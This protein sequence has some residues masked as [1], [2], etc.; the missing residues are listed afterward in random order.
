[1]SSLTVK[2]NFLDAYI[3]SGIF[4]AAR[5][6]VCFVMAIACV[7]SVFARVLSPSL[8]AA[9]TTAPDYV[10]VHGGM[11]APGDVPQE[12][13]LPV[14]IKL[15]DESAE[16]PDEVTVL[17]RRGQFVLAY[18]PVGLLNEVAQSG[19]ISRMEGGL[20]RIPH[21][22]H[23]REFTSFPQVEE[24]VGLPATYTGKNVVTGFSDT[25]FDPHHPAFRN[26]EDGTLRVKALTNYGSTPSQISRLETSEEIN[27]WVTDLDDEWHATHVAG[28]MAGG[29]KGNLYYGIATE[30]DI[31]ATTGLL[32]DATMLA[33][34]ED[35]IEYARNEG[36]PAVINLSVSSEIGPHD[37]TSLFSQY[38]RMLGDEAV[39]CIA[40]G[41]NGQRPAYWRTRFPESTTVGAGFVDVKSWSSSRAS[42][43]MD[44]WSDDGSSFCFALTVVNPVTKEVIYREEFPAIKDDS[45]ETHYVITSSLDYISKEEFGALHRRVSKEFAKY[46]DGYVAVITEINPDNHRFNAYV[47]L[48]ASSLQTTDNSQGHFQ[49]GIEVSG[50]ENTGFRAYTSDAVRYEILKE[51]PKFPYIGA[52]GAINDFI[53]GDGVIGIGAMTS[54]N[55]WPLINGTEAAGS[56]TEGAPASFSS[57]STELSLPEIS[58]PG[59][60]LVSAISKPFLDKHPD[61]INSTSV[62]SQV[63]NVDYYWRQDCGTSMSTPYVAGVCAL[64][65]EAAP[66][67]SPAQV[68][69][70]LLST[71]TPP[72]QAMEAVPPMGDA[73]NPRWGGGMLNSYAAVREAVRIA[74]ID[75]VDDGSAGE[76]HLA[77]LLKGCRT[78]ADL[79]ELIR[80]IAEPVE[81]YDMM[82]R[83]MSVASL[84]PGIFIVRLGAESVKLTLE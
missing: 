7:P 20:R 67:L 41:N 17:R 52:N 16:L 3:F 22:L 80:N 49:L 60:Y 8:L 10:A 40:A 38:V 81:V 61:Y 11:K 35:V 59:A 66:E 37:G 83:R 39:I 42:G 72:S 15:T 51:Y 23:A 58:A 4:P 68:K 76:S 32:Y 6:I 2:Y 21:L 55:T 73:T 9:Q 14:I 24:A 77:L 56:Y 12:V 79:A 30:S 74:G 64:V 27:A 18:V 71:L 26:C 63:D 46:F 70:I 82:G 13:F 31:V 34:M 19:Q 45:P 50:R 36:K 57:Y 25:G 53:T 62:C 75:N 28:I 43:I 78:V 69:E 29:Y 84:S 5:L 33:G 47:K 44:L 48:E 1:M 54:S 65:L